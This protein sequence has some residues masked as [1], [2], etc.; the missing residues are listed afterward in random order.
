MVMVEPDTAYFDPPPRTMRIL[1]WFCAD[2]YLEEVE[3]DLYELFQEEVEEYGLKKAK[4]R[5]F[6]TAIRYLK[7]FF[8]GKKDFTLQ[9]EYHLT[10]LKHYLKIAFRQLKKQQAYSFINISGLAIAMACCIVVLVYVH[11]ETSYDN[12]HPKAEQVYRLSIR[13]LEVGDDNSENLIAASPILWGPA[14]KKDYPEVENYTRFVPRTS[15]DNPW[16]I[17]V[18]D[19]SFSEARILYTDP[20][21]MEM[22]NWPLVSGDPE[23]ALEDPNTIVI[24]EA[25]AEKYFKGEDPMGKVLTIDP[26]ERDR[27]G[28]LNGTTYDFTVSAI[29][30]NVPERS[31]FRFDFLL[32]SRIL[33]DVY[34][35]DINGEA[36]ISPWYW[37]GL[38]GYTYLELKPGTDVDAFA[39]KF[40]SFQERYVGDATR[41]RGY[42]YE[43]DLQRLDQIYLD[44]ERLGQMR[45]VG[46]KTYLYVFSLVALFILF[47]ACINFMNLATARSAMRAKEVGLRKVVGAFRKQLIS[48]FLGES[49]VISFL[50]FSIAVGLAW[51]VL[52]FFY[53]YL[54]KELFI[55]YAREAPFLVSLLLL[56]IIVG[57]IAGSYPAF[58]LSRFKPALVLKGVYSKT[59]KGALLRKGLVV[60]QFMISAFFIIMTITLFK[61]I[62]FMRN[63]DLGFDQERVVVIPPN[64]A[65]SMASQYEAV[66]GELL[67]DP[68]FKDVTMSSQV[69]GQPGRGGDLYVEKGADI[70]SSFSLDETFVDYN[71]VDLFGLELLAGEEFKKRKVDEEASEDQEVV[72]ILNEQAVRQF[73]WASPQ[74]A[75][76][77]QIVRDPNAKDWTARIVGV[78]KD[79]HS[80]SLREEIGPQALIQMPRYSFMSIKLKTDDL[81]EGIAA[82]QGTVEK[83]VKDVPFEYNFLDATF[84]EQYETEAQLSSVFT[85]I[86][87]LAIFIAC[88]GLFGLAT[89]TTAARIKEVGIRKTLGASVQ[90]I[91]FLLSKNFATLILIAGLVAVPF[92]YLATERGLEYFAYTVNNSIGTYVVAV[93]GALVIALITIAFQT[94]RAALS[95]PVESL[96]AE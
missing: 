64:V 89:F 48:Q 11:D 79:F 59:Q 1:R 63:Y 70:E 93:I 49:V 6:L 36:D 83:F 26:K 18:G 91:V 54:G 52:P 3:G 15:P 2:I 51:M 9:L 12:Y 44:G 50:A 34:G 43:P 58:F 22:F 62:N 47:L 46:D 82:I 56:G 88:M 72:A 68:R 37:R 90:D 65:Q 27:E 80:E 41:S 14:L 39:A 61:Q 45:P 87:I 78:V 7:P 33:N 74:E 69:P 95:N 8:Y 60:F 53:E 25:M 16:E 5:F 19:R 31:H 96:R 94:I 30:S 35:G 24:T 13:S 38:I 4:R 40:E 81:Q 17:T 32:P 23:K 76:G 20:S 21:V 84:K 55:D 29:I 28:N 75:I 92:A 57:I 85:Y 10:M 67:A 73:G 77:K 71:Y 42:Y 66:R 86:S